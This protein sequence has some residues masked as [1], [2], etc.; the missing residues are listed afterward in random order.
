MKSTY[1]S[2]TQ[3]CTVTTEHFLSSPN[4]QGGFSLALDLNALVAND[5]LEVRVYGMGIAGG[6]SRQLDFMA[7]YGAQSPNIIVVSSVFWNSLTDTNALRFSIKQ[8]F[9]TS[10]DIPWRVILDDAL[11]PATSGR[12]AVVDANGLVDANTVKVGPTGSG[13]AQTAGDIPGRLTATRAGLLDKLLYIAAS[14]QGLTSGAGT[15]T[16]NIYDD[17][18]VTLRATFTIVGNNRTA[19]TRF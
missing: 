14:V 8:T 5:V 16:F 2:G 12:T 17:D 6:T 13:T 15:G 11:A 4:A 3:T 18:G 1:A 10:R 9:G 7:Y 19:V